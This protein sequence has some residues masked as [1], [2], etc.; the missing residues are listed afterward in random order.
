MNGDAKS[1]SITCQHDVMLEEE[2]ANS[3]YNRWANYGTLFGF[4]RDSFVAISDDLN[5]L[6][7]NNAPNLAIHFTSIYYRTLVQIFT[8]NLLA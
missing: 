8:G 2:I 6:L 5:T 3:T 1:E 4:T 7:K